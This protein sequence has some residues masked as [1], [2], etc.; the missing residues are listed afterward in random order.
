[1]SLVMPGLH[2]KFIIA[3]R[4]LFLLNP[5]LFLASISGGRARRKVCIGF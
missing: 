5:A 2:F 1:M 3:T 4:W